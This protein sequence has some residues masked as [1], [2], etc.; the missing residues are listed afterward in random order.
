MR[1]RRIGLVACV[2][3]VLLLGV[4][5]VVGNRAD[6]AAIAA[7]ARGPVASD[8]WVRLPAAAGRPAAGYAMLMGGA[9]DDALTGASSPRAERIE[10][11]SM[12]AENGVMRMRR[13]AEIAVPAGGMV[14]LEPGGFHLMIFGLDPAVKPGE[15]IP[16]RLTFRSGAVVELPARARAAGDQP[17]ANAGHAH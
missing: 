17:P 11:H 6:G 1:A 4:S 14:M 3:A 15:I 2:L 7:P 16:L 9:R 12:A 5:L 13:Q 10:L 8:G